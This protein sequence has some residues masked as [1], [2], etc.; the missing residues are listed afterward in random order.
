MKRVYSLNLASYLKMKGYEYKICNDKEKNLKYFVF[1]EDLSK[2]I[3]KYKNNN[4]LQNFIK[5]F[6]DIKREV[7]S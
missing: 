4:E 7:H 1:D 6:K 5:N 3:E 2:E